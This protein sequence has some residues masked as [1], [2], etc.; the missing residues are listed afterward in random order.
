MKHPLLKP[1]FVAIAFIIFLTGSANNGQDLFTKMCTPCHTIGKG[2]LV[3]PDLINISEKRTADWLIPYIQSSQTL[4]KSGDPDAMAVYKEYN[5]LL[6]PD[7]PLDNG[8]VLEVLKYI[9]K[10]SS[11]SGSETSQATAVDFL[12]NATDEDIAEGVL[13]FSGKKRLTNGGA[14]CISCHSV[15]DDRIFSSGTLAKEL[16]ESHALMGSAGVSA[17]IRSSPFP[18]MGQTY[19]DN[20]LTEEEVFALTAY[21]KSVS[22]NRVYQ[23]PVDYGFTFAFYGLTV[24][25]L[26]LLIAYALYFNRKTKGVHHEIHRRQSPVIN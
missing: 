5:S 24:F 4:I 7:Q 8:Q 9:K 12:A 20:P 22:D 19:N 17:I 15:K 2:R 18:A 16:T 6:M 3:G 25:M 26:L 14:S 1:L 21:L 13:L 10:T 23:I 11:G